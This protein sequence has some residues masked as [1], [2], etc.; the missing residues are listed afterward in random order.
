MRIEEHPGDGQVGPSPY[1]VCA[2]G[3]GQLSLA[4]P[5]GRLPIPSKDKVTRKLAML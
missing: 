3:F 2:D 5:G 4:G 1:V